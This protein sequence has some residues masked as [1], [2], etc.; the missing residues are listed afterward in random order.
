MEINTQNSILNHYFKTS[1]PTRQ[2]QDDL[3]WINKFNENFE[4][5]LIKKH[6][7]KIKLLK[8]K[9]VQPQSTKPQT[10]KPMN[11][12]ITYD[13]SNVINI[14]KIHLS[15]QQLKV[16]SKG[17]KFVPTP[18]SINTITT[19][20][21]CE[22]SLFSTS[23]LIKSAAISEISTFIQKWRKPTKFNMNKEEV[24]LLKEIKTIEDIVIVQADKGGKIVVMNKNDYF[25]KIEEKLND[26]NVYEQVKKDPTT[27]IKTEINKK[28]TKMLNQNKITD[29]NKYYLTSIDDLPK[30]RGQPKLHKIDT[31]MRIVTCSR[32]TITSPISQFIFRI[33]KELRTTLNG[34]VCNTSKFVKIISDVK[35]NQDE[36]LASLDIQDLYTNIPVSKAI[37]ITLK[38]LDESKKLDNLPFTKTDIKELLNLALKN[39]YFQFNGKFYKQKT[40]LPMGN[41]L[42]P[43]LA[44]IYMDEYQKQHLHEVNI[45]NKI[46]R[47][48]DD[49][50]I[51]TKMNKPQ[52]E[53]YVY[54]LNKIRGTIK[55][56]SEFEQNDQINYLDTMLTKTIINN[57]IILK[58]RWFRK[59]TA[60]DRLLNYESS[61]GKSIKNNIVKNMTAR[62]LETTQDNKDQQ[63]DLNKLRDMLLRSNYPLREIEKLIKQ[64]CQEFKSNK[65]KNK[66]N[67]KNDDTAGQIKDKNNNDFICSLTLPYA[68]GMEVLKRR[69]EKKLKIKLFFSYPYKLQSQFNQSLKVPSKS[70]IYQIPCS[71]KQ[72][73][74]GQTKVGI[75]NRMKQHSKTIN[76]N[77]NNSNSEMVK[78]FQEKK[79]QCL[80]DPND[81]FI[82]EEEKDY[83]KRR[84]KEAIYSIIS[85]SVNTH[86]EINAAWTPILHKAK[87][88]IQR[89]IESARENYNKYKRTK[90]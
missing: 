13:T 50:L 68:P 22:K 82:I 62:I 41:T 48:V 75:D 61:H 45:P 11:S 81:A 10:T 35:L 17:L 66:S 84:T 1:Q 63:E 38:R 58:V 33:I 67:D 54:D 89:K 30:I 2:H 49:I 36:H 55:F 39:S 70:V 57:E 21:N 31:P 51:I 9:Q 27:I 24:K 14:S 16:I 60:A 47:Y 87:H 40:G 80:F 29:Q 56:T 65:N 77:E 4:N 69:L 25:N 28:V 43:I 71:C 64:T 73:Y 85:E 23:K 5:K 20:V 8:E 59:D 76:D 19:V 74:V 90:T 7:K 53:K 32:D 37:D 44:D 42:S 83:W 88:Q 15:Q 12:K 72:T 46:W 79:F 52:L 78:H 26:L 18:T 3:R 86:D 6:D 34:V